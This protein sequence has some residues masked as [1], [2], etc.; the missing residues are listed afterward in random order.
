[1]WT[2]P[3]G[4]RASACPR[5]G[6]GSRGLASGGRSGLGG[7]CLAQPARAAG[8]GLDPVGLRLR[9]AV[10]TGS[11][12]PTGQVIRG[13]AP[14]REVIERC[15]AIPVPEAPEAGAPRDPI[16]YAGGAGNVVRGEG[17]RRGVGFAV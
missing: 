1:M 4:V 2:A 6:S 14:D 9:N 8:A 7:L 3:S 12:L 15:A 17:L 11:V 16:A 5:P 10:R 13:S